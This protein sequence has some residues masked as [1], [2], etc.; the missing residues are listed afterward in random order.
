MKSKQAAPIPRRIRVGAKMYSIDIVETMH[1][2]RE[3]GRTTYGTGNIQIGTTSNVTGKRYSDIQMSETFWHEM[4]HAILYEMGNKLHSDE[5]FVD[6]F[7]IHLARAIRS[8]K[9]K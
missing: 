7:A 3:M 2:K 4:V 1:R 9:F 8:A 6:T 5:Q